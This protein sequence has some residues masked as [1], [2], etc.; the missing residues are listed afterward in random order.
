MKPSLDPAFA[1][2]GFTP[3][4]TSQVTVDASS[5]RGA[6]ASLFYQHLDGCL[7]KADSMRMAARDCLEAIPSAEEA[8]CDLGPFAFVASYLFS[9]GGRQFSAIVEILRL[10]ERLE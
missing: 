1:G 10:I 8:L 3:R 5:D 9:A 7:A 4:L 6:D 2:E